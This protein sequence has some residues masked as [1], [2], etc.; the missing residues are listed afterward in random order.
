M[1]GTHARGGPILN[2]SSR[3]SAPPQTDHPET[4]QEPFSYSSGASSVRICDVV[5]TAT[6]RV[7][8]RRALT[9]GTMYAAALSRDGRMRVHRLAP[10]GRADDEGLCRAGS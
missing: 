4:R 2:R 6:V 5:L 9:I 1:S 7:N 3:L 10:R 8:Q